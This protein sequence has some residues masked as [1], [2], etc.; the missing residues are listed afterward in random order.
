MD[1]SIYTKNYLPVLEQFAEETKGF[2][3]KGYHE[4]VFIPY[5]FDGYWDADFKV[6]YIGQDTA[7][8]LTDEI[9]EPFQYGNELFMEHRDN[10]TLSEY[11]RLNS[12]CVTPGR[13]VNGS[14]KSDGGFWNFI[15]KL[16]IR[17][18][19]G[20]YKS[21]LS[22]LSLEERMLINSAGYGEAFCVELP[23]SL[24]NEYGTPDECW[25]D[26]DWESY[27]I[28]STAARKIADIRLLLETFSPD[29]VVITTGQEDIAL[30]DL[31]IVEA[32][33]DE[34]M[35]AFTVRGFNTKFIWTYHPRRLRSRFGGDENTIERIAMAFEIWP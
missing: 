16:H 23:K 29:L 17:L 34:M 30:S 19:T 5:A 31:E 7:Y 15:Q 4:G 1:K 28:V 6:F 26:N 9:N 25:E 20:E 3:D 18:C 2:F 24:E 14:M 21:P 32:F 27:Q 10:N 22:Q 13:L 33:R 12:E 35:T 8:W 11:L